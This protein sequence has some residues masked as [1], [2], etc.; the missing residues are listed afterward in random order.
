[1]NTAVEIGEPG[2]QVDRVLFPGQAIDPR[3]CILPLLEEGPAQS[4][5][6]DM[7][8]QRR[9]LLLLVPRDCLP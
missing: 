6:A 7:V 9:E 3:R 2:L 4:V 1:M 5:E 8:Q